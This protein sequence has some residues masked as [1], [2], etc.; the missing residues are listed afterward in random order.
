MLRFFILTLCFSGVQTKDDDDHM[1]VT[2]GS[3]IKIQSQD[4]RYYLSSEEKKLGAGSGQQIVTFQNDEGTQ[5]TL[6]LV[7]PANHDSVTEYPEGDSTCALAKPIPCNTAIRLTHLRTQRNL[8]SH[9]VQSPLS[10]QQE[11]TGYGQGDGRGDGGDDWIVRCIAPKAKYWKRGE[12]FHL[13]H[14]DTSKFLGTAKTLEF[15]QRTCGG[16]C[17]IMGHL[18]AFGRGS[19]DKHTIFTVEQGVHIIPS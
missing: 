7:R 10:S 19:N 9:G 11:V 17:P 13:F 12:P 3:A 8:H 6:W 16:N 4:T 14:R 2:C 18:E 1:A 15:N 5:D